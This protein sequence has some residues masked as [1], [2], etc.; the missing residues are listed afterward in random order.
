MKTRSIA[1][2][3]ALIFFCGFAGTTFANTYTWNNSGNLVWSSSSTNW[4][5]PAS[6]VLTPWDATNGPT[7]VATFANTTA[8]TATLSGSPLV[9]NGI[10]FAAA[11]NVISGGT[12][13]FAGTSP[14]ITNNSNN[15][16]TLNCSGSGSVIV[17]AAGSGAIILNNNTNGWSNG[18]I[19]VDST[20]TGVVDFYGGSQANNGV[21][22][23]IQQGNAVF[24]KTNGAAV[25]NNTLTIMSG[26]NLSESNSGQLASGAALVMSGGTFN[27]NT[28]TESIGN[29]SGTGGTLTGGANSSFTTTPT[30]NETYSGVIGGSLNFSMAGAGQQLT[31]SGS[32]TYTGETQITAGTLNVASLSNYGVPSAIGARLATSDTTAGAT[33]GLHFRGGTL[34]Y[35]GSTAQSTNRQIRLL[36]V[37]TNTID[38]SGSSGTA[39]MAFTYSGTNG[40]QWDTPGTRTLIL[41]GSNTGNNLFAL[42]LEDQSNNATSLIKNG[43]GTWIVSNPHNGDA[44]ASANGIF[45]GYSGG[46]TINAGTLIPQAPGA[47][48]AA[49]KALA[50]AGGTLDI[51]TD[52]SINGLNTTVSGNAAIV[53]DRLTP[54]SPGI[55]QT[56]GTLSIGTQTL[57]VTQG[58][59]ATGATAGVQFGA[60]TLSGSATVSPAAGATLTLGAVTGSYPLTMSGPGNLLLNA[61]GNSNS[62]LI[63]SNG[64]TTISNNNAVSNMS[65]TVN[66]PGVLNF[67]NGQIFGVLNGNGTINENSNWLYTN[68]TANGTYSGSIN[69]NGGYIK[70]STGTETLSGSNSYTGSTQIQGGVLVLANSNAL[71]GTTSINFLGGTLQYAAGNTVDYSQ[72]IVSSTSA[73]AI[74][75][76][77]QAVTYAG[78]LAVDQHGRT[79]PQRHQRHEGLLDPDRDR[80]LRRRDDRHRR[81]VGRHRHG[82]IARRHRDHRQR[83]HAL[84]RAGQR[85]QRRV[86]LHRQQRR[87]RRW[88]RPTVSTARPASPARC[89]C[90]T[91]TPWPTPPSR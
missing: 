35:T 60:T 89:N 86:D 6:P 68:S 62:G 84:H 78:T 1:S 31:L 24:N 52:S 2:L 70:Q 87:G 55:T 79:D 44:A 32:N 17:N 76:N 50:L 16:Q 83:R 47:F 41:T 8:G 38:A 21:S 74:N 3:A 82:R 57:A 90:R 22:V 29:F 5:V 53:S 4:T 14:F 72:L 7:D 28:Y 36:D 15:T 54:S 37:T 39:S 27:L 46:T 65:L 49:G 80:G 51:Q 11:A 91:P 71:A 66:S 48:G 34:Q 73:V 67:N 75:T 43:V 69:G 18:L 45:G 30:S 19:T 88:A 59:N 81:T 20:G 33:S 12:L 10:N 85:D 56:L 61:T 9:L 13:A 42:N 26:G 63:L 77:G 23:T 58:T 64:T 25:V 40:N